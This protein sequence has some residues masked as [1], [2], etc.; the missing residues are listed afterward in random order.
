MDLLKRPLTLGLF[1]MNIL[2]DSTRINPTN[3]F[4]VQLKHL[5]GIPSFGTVAS[6]ATFYSDQVFLITNFILLHL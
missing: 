5:M 3:F 2:V 6:L 1:N 4:Y